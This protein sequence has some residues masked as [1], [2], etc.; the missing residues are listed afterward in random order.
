[1][2]HTPATSTLLRQRIAHLPDQPGVYLFKDAAGTILYVGKAL[3]LRK[4][5]A[6][7]VHLPAAPPSAAQAGRPLSHLGPR[8]ARMVAC[9]TDVEVRQTNSEAEALLLEAQLIKAH[10]PYYNVAFRDDKAY[11][12]L[13]ITNEPFPRL[14]VTRRKLNDGARY[15]GPYTDAGLM[16]EAVRFLR[17]V[18][19][20]RTC[21]TFPKTPCLEYHL[22]QCLAPCVQYINERAYQRMVEDLAALLT[23]QRDQ[24]LHELS[25][26]MTQASRDRRFEEASRLRDQ[27][28]ALSSVIVAKEKSLLA[29]PLEQLQAALKLPRLPRRIEAFDISNLFGDHAVGS[30]VVFEDGKPRKAHYRHFRIETVQGIDDYQMMREVVRRRYHG[31]LATQ[32]PLPDLILIDGGKGQLGAACEELASLQLSIPAM[33]LAKRFEHIF[34]PQSEKPIV[35]LPT[36][37]VLHLV[38]HV[39]DEAHRFAIRYH[40][41]I[42]GKTARASVLDPIR[43]IGP[44][45]K[46]QLLRAFGSVEALRNASLEQLVQKAHVPASVAQQLVRH[47]NAP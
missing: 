1:M 40:R 16:H 3:S 47:F 43:G 46:T 8:I 37:P 23:G 39:R 18:F 11:P 15:F 12:L 25:R 27:I 29:G 41:T 45:R 13:K 31:T 32:L 26:R 34:L 21:K 36:S 28:Q 42:R 19:P 38:Q 9:V 33:G 22:G 44:K 4:R 17:R 2:A 35:L 30:M 10:L 6:S 14:V 5:V 24:L 20:L 7:Y